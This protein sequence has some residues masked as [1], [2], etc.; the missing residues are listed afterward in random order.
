MF[1]GEK[2]R[3]GLC[4]AFE[5]FEQNSTQIHEMYQEILAATFEYDDKSAEES[6]NNICTMLSI[7]LLNDINE[8][9]LPLSFEE[10]DI[11]LICEIGEKLILF[12]TLEKMVEKDI[13]TKTEIDGQIHYSCKENCKK[14][15]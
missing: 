15:V 9:E 2:L 14:V 11:E 12:F 3:N 7:C 1:I 8:I 4:D 5:I 10:N 6:H 13:I